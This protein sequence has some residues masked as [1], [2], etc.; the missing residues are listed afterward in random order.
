MSK[1]SRSRSRSRGRRN[2]SGSRNSGRRNRS[3][4]R[5]RRQRSRSGGK[6]PVKRRSRTRSRGGSRGRSV[7]RS[8]SPRDGPRNK[9]YIGNLS[10]KTREDDIEHEFSRHGRVIDIYLPMDRDTGRPRGFGFLTFEDD[11]SAKKAVRDMDGRQLDGREL[12]VEIARAK[13]TQSKN[14]YGDYADRRR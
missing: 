7:S 11:R 2:R 6:S 10:F 14:S 3:G 8:P 9:V 4:S 13:P 1:Y 5:S 12:R